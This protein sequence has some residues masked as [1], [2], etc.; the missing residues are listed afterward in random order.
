MVEKILK[1]FDKKA[2]IAIIISLG[3]IVG[4]FIWD[5]INTPVNT[6][7]AE[8]MNLKTEISSLTF[9]VNN[10]QSELE[11][12]KN[13]AIIND[14]KLKAYTDK[15]ITFVVSNTESK[16]KEMMLSVLEMTKDLPEKVIEYRP[17]NKTDTV[18]IHTIEKQT[19]E[20]TVLVK[21]STEKKG[22]FKRIFQ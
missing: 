13:E 7:D 15:K 17:T 18:F 2:L 10:I 4:Y 22:L 14:S 9:L 3:G 5:K 21:D 19:I 11:T 20:K 12:A 16:N 1:L 6:S 8:I